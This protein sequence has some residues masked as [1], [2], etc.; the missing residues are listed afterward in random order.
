MEKFVVFGS[1][2]G[3]VEE[4][5]EEDVVVVVNWICVLEYWFGVLYGV[6]EFEGEDGVILGL[7]VGVVWVVVCVDCC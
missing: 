2:E 3:I 1:E 7:G 6:E 5:G 4:E